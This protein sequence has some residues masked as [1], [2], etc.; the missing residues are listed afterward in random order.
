MRGSLAQ[1][2]TLVR[3]ACGD[4]WVLIEFREAELCSGFLQPRRR[5]AYVMIISQR[6]FHKS[7]QFLILKTSPPGHLHSSRRHA[8]LIL[9]GKLAGDWH[10]RFAVVRPHRLTTVHQP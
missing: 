1:S 7:I 6:L 3:R 9:I 2:L 10:G 5:N 8:W 4:G